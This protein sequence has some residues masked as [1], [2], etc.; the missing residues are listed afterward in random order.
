MRSSRPNRVHHSVISA[1]RA[2]HDVK[3]NR[4]ALTAPSYILN[5]QNKVSGN[6]PHVHVS[7]AQYHN[8]GIGNTGDTKKREHLKKPT[9]IEEI[10]EKKFIDRN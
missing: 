1:T 4:E 3:Y 9:K 2:I 7:I 8:M 6:Q 10:Q 5:S